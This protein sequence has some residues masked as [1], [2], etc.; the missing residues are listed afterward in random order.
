MIRAARNSREAETLALLMD[1]GADPNVPDNRMMTALHR[2]ASRGD[3]TAAALLLEAGADLNARD[4]LGGTPL[5]RATVNDAADVSQALSDA[6][7]DVNAPDESGDTPLHWASRGGD[8]TIAVL[9]DAGAD[10]NARNDANQTPLHFAMEGRSSSAET[11][12]LLLERGADPNARDVDGRTPLHIAARYSFSGTAPMITALLEAGA[13]A[14]ARAASGETPLHVAADENDDAGQLH[15][16]LAGGADPNAPDDQGATPLHRATA[17]HNLV[18]ARALLEVGAAVNARAGNGDTPLHRAVSTAQPRRRPGMTIPFNA[19][20]QLSTWDLA[21]DLAAADRDTALVAALVRAGADTE[22]RNDNGETALA[23]AA[24]R[25]NNRFVSKLL[26]LGSARESGLS[27]V[28]PPAI[29]VCD[30]ANYAMFTDAPVVSLEG[31]LEA[32]AEV[33]V[34]DRWGHSPLHAL[35]RGRPGGRFLPTGIAAL[36]GAG[37]DANARDAGGDTPLHQAAVGGFFV[38]RSFP[39]L[40]PLRGVVEALLAGGAD[41]N[42]RGPADRMPLHA[43]AGSP[44][45]NTPT[46]AVLLDAGADVNGRDESG[47]TP[48]FGASGRGGHPAIVRLLVRS[49]ADVNARTDNGETSLHRAARERNPAVATLLMELGAD[50]GLVD[51]SGTVADPASCDRWP[52]PVFFHHA[53]ADVVADCLESGATIDADDAPAAAWATDPVCGMTVAVAGSPAAVYNGRTL[54]FCCEGCRGLFEST[55]EAFA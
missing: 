29:P 8:L 15:A 13:D 55:P 42:G 46:V 10:V 34:L 33:S 12:A 39:S 26:E 35:V 30:W 16:L 47:G 37:A 41:V 32:G 43:A 24:K 50:P 38:G 36:L 18:A 48:L 23:T 40:F 21:N 53:T 5:H 2:V 51:D 17:R 45:D 25:G 52:D 28:T 3:L 20:P 44:F 7:A 6:G 9:L 49:G 1:A 4:E 19:P 14:N 27:V 31:C 11:V 54:H 22:A